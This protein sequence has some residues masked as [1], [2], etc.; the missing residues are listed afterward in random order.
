MI[1]YYFT[2]SHKNQLDFSSENDIL[3][4]LSSLLKEKASSIDTT[5]IPSI[6]ASI[7]A[8]ISNMDKIQNKLIQSLKRNEE[9]KVNQINKLS[10]LVHENGKLKE[11]SESFIPSYIKCPKDYIDKIKKASDPENPNLKIIN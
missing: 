5:L 4:K 7:K 1:K 10:R 3:E 9:Q 6:N 8:T 11:R 2:N